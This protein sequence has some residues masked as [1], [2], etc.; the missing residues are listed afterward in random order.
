MH[1]NNKFCCIQGLQ[2]QC[3]NGEFV[4]GDTVTCDCSSDIGLSDVGWYKND[5]LLSLSDNSVSISVTTDNHGAVYM[6]SKPGAC[7]TLTD[8]VT[9]TFTGNLIDELF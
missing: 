3:S 7:G 2:I 6:C 5:D 4:I 8:S 1:C 9:V